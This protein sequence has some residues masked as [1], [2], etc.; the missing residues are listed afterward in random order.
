MLV[1]GAQQRES[2]RHKHIFVLFQI[3]FPYRLLQD[4]ELPSLGYTIG[5][6]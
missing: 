2:V 1:S 5:V 4:I 6:C 3:L